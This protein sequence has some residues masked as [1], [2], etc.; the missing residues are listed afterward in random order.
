MRGAATYGAIIRTDLTFAEQTALA[1]PVPKELREVP[2]ELRHG[3]VY[4]RAQAGYGPPKLDPDYWDDTDAYAE[5]PRTEAERE[6]IH[7]WWQTMVWL[8]R[9]RYLRFEP[10]PSISPVEPAAASLQMIAGRNRRRAHLGSNIAVAQIREALRETRGHRK[11]AAGR[12]GISP[13]MLSYYIKR[14]EI[15]Q[16]LNSWEQMMKGAHG[17]T[18][19]AGPLKETA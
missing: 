11:N 10:A 3:E 14:F 1:R 15:D 7:L 17:V 19:D 13:R 18:G 5:T 2:I 12:L 8:S 6:E 4:V 9:N 16:D